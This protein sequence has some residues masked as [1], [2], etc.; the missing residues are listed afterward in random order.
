MPNAQLDAF[1]KTQGFDAAAWVDALGVI[2]KHYGIAYS[3]QTALNAAAYPTETG[4]EAR[5]TL[6]ARKLGLRVKFTSHAKLTSWTLPAICGFKD[7]TIG[8]LNAI[9]AEGK[10]SILMNGGED[11]VILPAANLA[12]QVDVVV[13]A[14]PLRTLVDARVDTYIAPYKLGWMRRLA[15]PDLRPYGYVMI[16]SV[17]ANILGLSGILFS[18]QVY[19][20]VVPA[21]SFSTLHVLF[22]GVVLAT[23]FDFLMRRARTKITDT[24]GKRADLRLSDEVFGHALRVKN[25]ARPRSTGSFVAQLRDLESIRDLLTSSTVSALAD[26]PFF[27]IFLVFFWYLGGALVLV[28]IVAVIAMI[29]PSLLVQRRLSRLVNEGMREA[30]MRNAMLIEAVQGIEDIKSLQAEDRFQQRWNHFNAVTAEASLRQ[31]NITA[32]LGT[33]AQAVQ[34]LVF[35]LIILFGAPMVIAGDLT[36]GTL[37]ACSILGPRIMS[38]MAQVNGLLTRL[39]QAKLSHKSIDTVLQMPVDHPDTE[40]RISAPALMGSY[41]LRGTKFYHDPEKARPVL[42]IEDLKIGAGEK[43]ALVGRIGSGKSTLLNALGGMMEAGEGEILLDDL[44]LAH[45]D[46]ADLRR[47]IGL[48]SQDSRL[49]HGSIRDNLTIGAPHASDA[50][51]VQA[52]SMTGAL[53]FVSRAAKGLDYQLLENGRGLSGGQ[54]QTLMLARLILRA[55][56]IV[57]LDE[58]TAAMDEHSEGQLIAALKDWTRERSLVVATHRM[59]VLDLVDR[60]IVVDQGKIAADLD[61]DRFMA[62]IRGAKKPR[63]GVPEPA[64]GALS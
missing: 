52:L 19:D 43:V 27:L 13:V 63:V 24:L 38:P 9:S 32:T 45:I 1:P 3:R 7:G 37:V 26:L 46:P 18:K 56:R 48:L 31:R 10:V 41:H 58:P 21:E 30:S 44:A 40:T 14:R 5:I 16:A 59:K 57:L 64:Q 33:W 4:A 2:A 12:A 8:V 15:M 29:L 11:L 60:V 17:T 62:K 23:L 22:V 50:Q 42:S 25:A 6:L 39:Q 55:P 49:F 54:R 36:T 28:P 35:A 34:S 47:D 20:R 51:I 53:D 61:K